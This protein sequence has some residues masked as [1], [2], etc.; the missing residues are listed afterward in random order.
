M[1]VR[2]SFVDFVDFKFLDFSDFNLIDFIEL[3]VIDRITYFCIEGIM[4]CFTFQKNYC[5]PFQH[6]LGE[7]SMDAAKFVGKRS[8]VCAKKHVYFSKRKMFL[9]FVLISIYYFRF[10]FCKK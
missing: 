5:S 10:F 1:L 3:L 8:L 4:S 2:C 7:V 9:G 6:L